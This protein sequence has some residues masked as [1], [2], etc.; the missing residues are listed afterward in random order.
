[1]PLTLIQRGRTQYVI[2]IQRSA[3]EA[4]RFAAEEL[5]RYLEKIAGA[6]IPIE[7]N[8]RGKHVI[9]LDAR[10]KAKSPD[11]FSIRTVGEKLVMRGASPRA[12]VFAVYTFLE[13]CLGCGW[14]KPGDDQIPEM[15]EVL[16]GKLNVRHQP[17]FAT[18]MLI[19]FPY[20]R[21]KALQQ[22][23]WMA[24]RKLSE[25]LLATNTN[26]SAWENGEV[27][28]RIIPELSKRG[29]DLR[30]TGHAFFAWLPPARYF[31]KHPE[32]FALLNGK[33][34]ADPHKASLCL[35]NP[36]VAQEV[37]RNIAR[38]ATRY[39]ELRVITLW[40]NDVN[41]FCE[42][43]ACATMDLPKE[44]CASFSNSHKY[45]RNLKRRASAISIT[46]SQLIFV[47][48][49]AEQVE[50]THPGLLI[51]TLAYG[52][53]Y[54][55]SR[56]VKPRRNVLSGFAVFDKLLTPRCAMLPTNHPANQPIPE[57]IRGWRK[58]A[59]HFYIYEYYAL[60]HDFSFLLDV[61]SKD[62]RWY[63]SVGA[64]GISSETGM[65]NELH[66]FAFSKLAWNNHL[67]AEDILRSYCRA[68]YG[69]MA[70]VM[71]QHWMLLRKSKLQW[72]Y[73]TT[74]RATLKLPTENWFQKQRATPKW[75]RTEAKCGALLEQAIN[76]LQKSPISPSRLAAQT[77]HRV[78]ERIREVRSRWT[79]TSWPWYRVPD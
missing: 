15:N 10:L 8:A 65:W 18:R 59:R 67:S 29:L 43:E 64:T 74:D 61:M 4:E 23:D 42:C 62:L 16:I 57:Y 49:V 39:P 66:M 58:Q 79:E 72:D 26:L 32:Y 40:G 73:G 56:Y 34:E 6:R 55:P 31:K 33:R 52:Q 7:R 44:T 63:R 36:A 77:D 27:R 48:R 17:S 50:K 21:A 41:G 38:F 24:K 70:D 19:H 11:A 47:N 54:N 3:A 35:S 76:R 78:V 20:I 28:E 5:S 45:H 12:V 13:D 68:A 9:A 22:I 71:M 2:S 75:K 37:A 25:M 30:G 1:M 14:I 51:E 53:N 46:K 69:P 60:Y